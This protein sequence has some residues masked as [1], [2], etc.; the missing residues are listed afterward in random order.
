M[1]DIAVDIAAGIGV[2]IVADIAVDIEVAVAGASLAVLPFVDKAEPF[3]CKVRLDRVFKEF[4]KKSFLFVPSVV[5]VELD[6][7]YKVAAL[8]SDTFVSWGFWK[9]ARNP[10]FFS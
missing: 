7:V 8:D 5:V 6:M 9:H 1:V 2:G 10:P 4:S 3:A